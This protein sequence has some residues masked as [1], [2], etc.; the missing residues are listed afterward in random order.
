M[1]R[2]GLDT[3]TGIVR[4]FRRGFETHKKQSLSSITKKPVCPL[5]GYPVM[6]RSVNHHP[7]AM[8]G[9]DY[10][11]VMICINKKCRNCEYK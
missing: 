2:I 4:E 11:Y 9:G 7:G 1:Q 10:T 8:V 5:C 3:T 6:I